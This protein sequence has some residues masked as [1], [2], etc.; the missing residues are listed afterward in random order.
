MAISINIWNYVHNILPF[1]KEEYLTGKYILNNQNK[2]IILRFTLL[3]E[4]FLFNIKCF[5]LV[6]NKQ[7]VISITWYFICVEG[8]GLFNRVKFYSVKSYNKETKGKKRKSICWERKNNG[9]NS[10]S[11]TTKTIRLWHTYMFS[12]QGNW[13]HY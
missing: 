13:D 8:M 6:G 5:L 12:K 7:S 9:I 4:G 1:L 3:F 11:W 10:F 2:H